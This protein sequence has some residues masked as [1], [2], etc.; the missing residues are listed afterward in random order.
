MKQYGTKLKLS[1]KF[2]ALKIFCFCPKS[3][4]LGFNEIWLRLWSLCMNKSELNKAK[5]N[6]M[7]KSPYF[8]SKSY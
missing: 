5:K 6:F 8:Q 7:F 2:V 4:V 1:S 3:F